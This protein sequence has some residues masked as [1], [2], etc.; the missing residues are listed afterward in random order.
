[1]PASI[2]IHAVMYSIKNANYLNG[3]TTKK[4][5]YMEEK[6]MKAKEILLDGAYKIVTIETLNVLIEDGANVQVLGEKEI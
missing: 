6:K 2:M 5:V 4:K 3:M 1:M